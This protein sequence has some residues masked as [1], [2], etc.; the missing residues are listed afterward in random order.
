MD[1]NYSHKDD[2]APSV[3]PGNIT[4]RGF[5]VA[6][7]GQVALSLLVSPSPT[8]AATTSVG[9]AMYSITIGVQADM[10]YAVASSGNV[11]VDL[12]VSAMASCSLPNGADATFGFGVRAIGLYGSL[13]RQ[14]NGDGSAFLSVSADGSV[15]YAIPAIATNLLAIEPLSDG[16]GQYG[17]S[18]SQALA[19]SSGGHGKEVQGASA[20]CQAY[21][22]VGGNG[23]ST[24]L[25]PHES[26]I[27]VV[28]VVVA[29]EQGGT[30][31]T[32][33]SYDMSQISIGIV[34]PL[35][36]GLYSDLPVATIEVTYPTGGTQSSVATR[37][38]RGRYRATFPFI[39]SGIHTI[40]AYD[41]VGNLILSSSVA[42]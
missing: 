19:I 12:P 11:S 27:G 1:I 31:A 9:K 38:D 18:I 13:R 15:A 37:I 20:S 6:N 22:R 30:L 7:I 4:T 5:G 26:S 3:Q 42:L 16:K 35:R 25:A 23:R 32:S 10:S 33:W 34:A 2:I 40:R 21:L 36:Y 29:K 39:E 8:G 28:V 17:G 24:K 14:V 41:G